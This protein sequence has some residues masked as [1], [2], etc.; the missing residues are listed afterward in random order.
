MFHVFFC[1]Y[2][3]DGSRRKILLLSVRSVLR[4]ACVV[5]CQSVFFSS[6]S[7]L[8]VL[9]FLGISMECEFLCFP[10]L[11]F[12]FVKLW[13]LWFPDKLVGL[14]LCLCVC[15]F[16][17]MQ[18]VIRKKKIAS[19]PT[20]TGWTHVKRCLKLLCSSVFLHVLLWCCV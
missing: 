1:L 6:I 15:E 16:I 17:C 14:V 4:S 2:Q 19:A 5:V 7:P 10:L 9:P 3:R 18:E 11:F 8:L 20:T 13:L 12:N